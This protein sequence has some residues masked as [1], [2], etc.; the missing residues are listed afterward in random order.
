M[1]GVGG[2]GGGGLGRDGWSGVVRWGGVGC[3]GVGLGRVGWGGCA[4]HPIDRTDQHTRVE[5]VIKRGLGATC[6]QHT[7]L[8]PTCGNELHTPLQPTNQH[9]GGQLRAGIPGRVT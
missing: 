5:F 7:P 3:G 2:G 1:K 6:D 9:T 8:Q 4:C